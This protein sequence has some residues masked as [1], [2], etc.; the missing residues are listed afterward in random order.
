MRYL[1]LSYGAPPPPAG[2]GWPTGDLV[3]RLISTGEFVYAAGLADPSHTQVVEIRDGTPMVSDGPCAES[4]EPLSSI[5]I[6]DVASHDRAVQV[7]AQL[8]SVLGRI[9]VRPVD[10]GDDDLT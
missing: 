5:G 4:R 2:A 3:A 6:V 8:S 10:G 9:E 1:L 7:A